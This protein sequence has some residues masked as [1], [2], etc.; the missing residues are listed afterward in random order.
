MTSSEPEA[1]RGPASVPGGDAAPAPAPSLGAGPAAGAPGTGVPGGPGPAGPQAARLLASGHLHPAILLL[2]LLD[3]VRQ[4]LLPTILGLLTAQVWLLGVGVA[5]FV[6]GMAYAL[7]RY[8]T[9]QYWLT[10]DELITREGI[11]ERQERRI[12]VN[13]IQDLAF[14]QSILRRVLGLVVVS[15]ETASGQGSEARLD[16][17]SRSEGERLREVLLLLRER[18]AAAAAPAGAAAPA[19]AVPAEQVLF[20]SQGGELFALG[21]TNNRIGAILAALFGVYELAQQFGLGRPLGGAFGGAL[22][23]LSQSGVLVLAFV[24]VAIVF[25]AL[26][27]GWLVSVAASF[28]LFHDFTLARRGDVFQLRHGLLTRRARA[29]PRRRIQRV[30]VEQTFLRRL[31]ELAVV[32]A[33]SAGSSF[34]AGENQSEGLDVVVPLAGV[35]RSEAVVPWFLPGLDVQRVPWR[36]VSRMVIVRILAK[37]ALATAVLLGFALPLAGPVGLLA[38]VLLPLAW[39]VGV[40]SYRN[41]AYART[42]IHVAFR[43]GVLGRYRSF[44]PLHKVQAVVLSADPIDRLLGL[45]RL[46]VHVA[47]GAA[48]S[49]AHLP[50]AEAR[51]WMHELARDAAGARFVW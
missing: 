12:P 32:R 26:L 48:S 28:L 45:A 5:F 33:D 20:R 44:L 31:F 46:T 50:R 10:E 19:P 51:R 1:T 7:V 14:E 49:M 47:G 43:H 13:R 23:R 21:L 38:L 42:G 40:L 2:R 17:L 8:V 34:G 16:S 22:Q 41:L 9:F 4:A 25:L 30:L 11:L 15:V 29:L 37:G 39:L 24:A 3:G 36:P 35:A 18:H 27:G 6:L